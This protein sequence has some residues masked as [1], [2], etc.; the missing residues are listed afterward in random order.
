[1]PADLPIGYR[2]FT[3][4]IARPVFLDTDGRQLI[5]NGGGQR[6][7]GIWINPGPDEADEPTFIQGP[8]Q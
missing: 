5:I 1:M 4:A 8:R 2:L 7:P 3:D 6:V